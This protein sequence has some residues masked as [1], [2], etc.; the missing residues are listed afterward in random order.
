MCPQLQRRA[1][2]RLFQTAMVGCILRWES[3]RRGPSHH[4]PKA[5]WR[6]SPNRVGPS[7]GS[8]LEN[9]L[10]LLSKSP[11]FLPLLHTPDPVTAIFHTHRRHA[12]VLRHDPRLSDGGHVLDTYWLSSGQGGQ[13]ECGQVD[14]REAIQRYDQYGR[15]MTNHHLL[16]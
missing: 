12:H 8:S 4:A 13:V 1:V 11:H 16:V 7:I 6:I 3:R 14:P 2:R 15:G 10:D 5:T 9:P